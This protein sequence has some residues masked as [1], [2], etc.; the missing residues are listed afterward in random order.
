MS[1]VR[2]TRSS[3][4]TRSFAPPST[5]RSTSGAPPERAAGHLIQVAPGGDPD[6][7]N[8][9]RVAAD[10]ALATGAY[11]TAVDYLRRALAEPPEGEERFEVLLGLG[12]VER[13]VAAPDA[14]GRLEA[15]M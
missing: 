2:Q 11:S 8:A 7:V 5:T 12:L 3:S 13:R 9:L 15:A 6:V 10:R 4:S 14:L 1:S